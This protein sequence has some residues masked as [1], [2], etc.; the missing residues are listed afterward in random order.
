MCLSARVSVSGA[1]RCD[2]LKPKHKQPRKRRRK[3]KSSETSA[4]EW[5]D[6]SYTRNEAV[7][8]LLARRWT[9]A[10]WCPLANRHAERE[11]TGQCRQIQLVPSLQAAN[12]NT[13]L[14]A[15]TRS[16]ESAVASG[17]TASWSSSSSGLHLRPRSPSRTVSK[18]PIVEKV[19]TVVQVQPLP[20]SHRLGRY[21]RVAPA[22][23]R[24]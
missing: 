12:K 4:Q 15:S 9:V 16:P 11:W 20:Q 19:A 21:R 7:R 23:G 18:S 22:V 6:K 24:E 3:K 8:L 14:S 5:R 2:G 10:A 1:C 13:N 17:S